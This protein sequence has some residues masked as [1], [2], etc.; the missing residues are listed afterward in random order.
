MERWV[1]VHV[2][3]GGQSKGISSFLDH[4]MASLGFRTSIY[5]L[6]YDSEVGSDLSCTTHSDC[7]GQEREPRLLGEQNR[8]FL[9]QETKKDR[10]VV[11]FE[12]R[13]HKKSSPQ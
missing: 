6:P 8:S 9:E 1:I 4:C 11:V 2:H 7:L 5:S 10:Q 3:F 12:K 13:K